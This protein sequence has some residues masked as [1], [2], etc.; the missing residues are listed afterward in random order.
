MTIFG[1]VMY[2]IYLITGTG[3]IVQD[4]SNQ[5]Q[6]NEIR[7]ELLSSQT[8]TMKKTLN[9]LTGSRQTVQQR[10]PSINPPTYREEETQNQYKSVS[11]YL[12]V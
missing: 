1:T 9:K 12:Q 11:S 2:Y 10:P 4:M 8:A 6:A 3:D 5:V 7:I